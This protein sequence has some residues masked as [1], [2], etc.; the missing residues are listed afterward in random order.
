MQV[1]TLSL[2]FSHPSF[3]VIDLFISY[4]QKALPESKKE[5]LYCVPT[6]S[7][8]YTPPSMEDGPTRTHTLHTIGSGLGEGV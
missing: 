4:H 1:G 5:Y 8:S 3:G 6:V 7:Q 2:S